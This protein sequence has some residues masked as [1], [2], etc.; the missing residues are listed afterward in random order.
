MKRRLSL[1]SRALVKRTFFRTR[2]PRPHHNLAVRTIPWVSALFCLLL[3][4]SAHTQPSSVPREDFWVPDGPVHAIVETNGIVYIGGL[5][6]YI[7]PVSEAGK[8]GKA[9]D[10]ISGENL[11]DMPKVN[12]TIK[13]IIPDNAGGWFLGGLFSSVGGYPLTNLAH[14]RADRSIDTHWTANPDGAVLALVASETTLY[15]GGL[16][17][18]IG[19]QTRLLLAALDA[20]T[21]AVRS[22][23]ADCTTDYSSPS[24]NA[25]ALSGNRLFVGGYFSKISDVTREH[26]AS[27]DATTGQVNPWYPNGYI[28]AEVGA[29]VDALAVADNIIYVA[30]TFGSIGGLQTNGPTRHFLAALDTTKDLEAGVLP[31]NPDANGPVTSLAVTCDKL[32]V[33]GLFTRIGGQARNRLAAIDTSTGSATAWNPD[34]D[35]DVLRIVI[36]ANTVYAGGK[37]TQ[38]GGQPR[39]SLAALDI[40]TGLVTLWNPLADFGIAGLAVAGNTVI[41]GGALGPGGKLRQNVA[42]FDVRTGKPLDWA[43]VISGSTLVNAFP[44][45]GVYTLAVSSNTVYLGGPF[46]AIN[47]QTRN[48]VGAV[49]AFTGAVKDWNPNVDSIVSSLIVSGNIVYAGGRFSRIG[50]ASRTNIAALNATTGLATSWNPGANDKV[51]ALVRQGAMVYVGGLFTQIG[52]QARKRLAAISAST[53]LASAWNPNV[54]DQVS[55]ISISSPFLYL[56]GQFSI[57]GGQTRNRLAAVNLTTGALTCWDP[58]ASAGQNSPGVNSVTVSADTLCAGGSFTS[59]TGHQRRNMAVVQTNCPVNALPW[60][61]DADSAADALVTS[62]NSIFAGGSFQNV[63]SQYHPNFAVFPPVGAPLIVR[64]P[65]T[66]IVTN[67]Q[68]VSL[69]A[70]ASGDAPLVYQWQLNGTNLPGATRPSLFIASAQT[71]NSGDYT[72]VVTNGLGLVNSRRASI[73]VFE[74]VV[75]TAEPLS[76]IVAPGT[77]VILAVGIAGNPAPSFQWRLNGVNIP[78]A[79]YPTLS[80]TNA[81]PTNG[82]SYSALIANVGGARSSDIASLVVASPALPF[83]D[84]LGALGSTISGFSGLGSG[85]NK[86]ATGEVGEPNHA[87]KRGGKSLW[88]SWTAPASGIATFSTRGSSFDTLLAIYMG[89]NVSSLTANSSDDDSA[90]FGTSQAAFNA[91]AGTSYLVAID[92]FAGA[93]GD[94]VLSWSLDPTTVLF[95]RLLNQPLSQTVP[96]GST[97]SFGPMVV[98]SPTPFNFQWFFGCRP[99][100]G[101]TNSSLII[102][103]AQNADVGSYR[104][105]V[106]NDSTRAAESLDAVLEIGLVDGHSYDKLE[107][108]LASA[109]GTGGSFRRILASSVSS[110]PSVSIG[111]LGSQILNNFNS[112]TQQEEPIQSSTIGGASRWYELTA[113]DQATMVIDTIGSDIDTLLSVYTGSSFLTLKEIARDNNGAPDGIR[114][115]VRFPSVAGTTYLVAVD[116]VNGAQ[117]NINL[118]WKMGFAPSGGVIPQSLILR[119]GSEFILQSG[120]TNTP[121]LFSYQ[122]RRNGMNIPGASDSYL[123]GIINSTD[124]GMYSVVVSNFVGVVT[125]GAAIVSVPL[126]LAIEPS[127]GA[128][129]F[130]LT[131]SVTQS[132]VLLW[133]SNLVVWI[134]LYTNLN[135]VLPINFLDRPDN[136]RSQSFYRLLAWP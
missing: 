9:F 42:A 41:A 52:G 100:P 68:P 99:I 95:P 130:R 6:D 22:W 77:S 133:S 58:N 16:F 114:S 26:I 61:P 47:G 124:G 29:R 116:G 35:N 34:A 53:G 25:L 109:S 88:L 113:L 90:G 30:G 117:G 119:Y 59:V 96:R 67:N 106:V 38:M 89:T 15:V 132:V 127:S 39:N 24:V 43:P 44:Y 27:V 31:W 57:V 51:T 10:R 87:G 135:P 48:H 64:H 93:S 104:V 32:Y 136:S 103:N 36:A 105:V 111:S 17:T 60:A 73:T 108:L 80:I 12:G 107:D 66:Q 82:G 70:E 78:G 14:I 76:Q 131:G 75:I 112:T 8:T 19:G 110:F 63:G 74:P 4:P 2:A 129:N 134:P 72:L 92:G 65:R 98:N 128:N 118:N 37:F 79:V 55:S 121:G 23:Q 50:G 120:E 126:H 21:G 28:G 86:T 85:S 40:N 91:I 102:P 81:Q 13:A 20:T 125:N 97:A 11:P 56:G 62:G 69:E 101:A 33:G 5:F 94:I 123:K 84:S 71:S 18:T 45:E 83:A 3:A 115:L 54:N 46:T 49:D 122:W 1:L 7:S